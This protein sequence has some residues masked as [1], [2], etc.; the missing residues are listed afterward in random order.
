[1]R[2]Y[3]CAMPYTINGIGTHYYGRANASARNGTCDSCHRN[4]TLT[5]YDTR[6]CFCVVFI[7]II[8]LTRYRIMD[9][10]SSCRR[11]RRLP[12]QQF[13]QHLESEI[14]PLRAA[15]AANP[16]D[17]LAHEKLIRTLIGFRMT[18]E[19]EDA[20]RKAVETLPQNAI[21]CRL[22][23]AIL[24]GKGDLGGAAAYLRRATNLDPSDHSAR[25]ALGNVLYL[26][27]NFTEA[28]RQLEEARRLAP[29][30][31]P[32]IY[33]L[34]ECYVQLERWPDALAAYQSIAGPTPEKIVL[35][36]IAECKRKLGY[37]LTPAERR[38]ARRWWP[39]G[40]RG[41]K[42]V[43]V[44]SVSAGAQVRP[45]VVLVGVVAV[46]AIGIIGAAIWGFYK[47]RN[48]DVFFDSAIPRTTFNVD[49][50]TFSPDAPPAHRTLSPGKHHVIVTDHNGKTI[51]TRD[52]DIEN[53]GF[54]FGGRKYVYNTAA[55]RVYKRASIDYAA[56]EN[57]AGYS[58]E[59][60]ALQPFFT[61]DHLDY[62]FEMP[63]QTVELSSGQSKTTKHAFLTTPMT[64]EQF[65]QARLS[66]NN[67]GDAEKALRIVTTFDPCNARARNLL[68]GTR[69]Q[70]KAGDDAVAIAKNGITAC[71]SDPISGH[72]LYQ[73]AKRQLGRDEEL[74][75]EYKSELD[76]HPNSAT[77]HYLYGRLLSG[78]D[79]AIPQHRIAIALDPKLGWAH[80]ALAYELMAEGAYSDAM[81]EFDA[82]LRTPQ[83]DDGTLLYYTYA[84]IASGQSAA[85][86]ELVD[87]ATARLETPNQWQA[88][89]LLALAD[90]RWVAAKQLYGRDTSPDAWFAAAR[91]YKLSGDA[92]AYAKHLASADRNK[93]LRQAAALMHFCD[94][95]ESGDWRNAALRLDAVPEH[96]HAYLLRLY[97]AAATMIGGNA[98][99]GAAQLAA[100]TKLIDDDKDLDSMSRKVLA[101]LASGLSTGD[102]TT[103]I[104][105]MHDDIGKIKDAYFLLGARALARGDRAHAKEL[106][107]RSAAASFDLSFPMLAA[108]RLAS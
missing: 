6:E 103:T 63:P 60:V 19:A 25:A 73:H 20:A 31:R 27:Q 81:H 45:K 18:A 46:I 77:A 72:R 66:E 42:K 44:A 2:T 70:Q 93:D 4:A 56:N 105:A 33:Q 100:V 32:A 86:H 98:P 67:L 74:L 37:E 5:S 88:K 104:R 91:L 23:G 3:T 83:H 78:P 13:K 22:T 82:A 11:H 58:E 36:R 38:A 43:K 76:A 68:V 47:G 7:P 35:R 1:M 51:E 62:V 71:A 97:A 28:A 89:W 92:D 29:D 8:P 102:E 55:L 61:I 79:N 108:Q 34:G 14:A 30:D 80:A 101:S 26:Q 41:P 10:C 54:S 50:D 96:E 52:I 9:E 69:L 99:D 53:E 49:G 64:L 57:D 65:A 59:L 106:F 85:A 16:S 24:S 87:P 107:R 39:F 48:V 15:I 21:L 17:A 12:L 84:A 40:R 75:A 94:A 90:K 95:I